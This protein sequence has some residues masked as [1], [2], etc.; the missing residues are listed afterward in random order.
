MKHTVQAHIE[1]TQAILTMDASF[2]DHF[3][4]RQQLRD[5]QVGMRMR[6]AQ[7]VM[8]TL[9]IMLTMLRRR[10]SSASALCDAQRTC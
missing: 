7:A 6:P 8:C 1:T 4:R 2:F 3:E 5:V 9:R 10:R